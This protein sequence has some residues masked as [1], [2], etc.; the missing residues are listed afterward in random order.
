[1]I[2]VLLFAAAVTGLAVS[3]TAQDYESCSI[4]P[5]GGTSSN[6]NYELIGAAA[7]AEFCG[8]TEDCAGW[9]YTP[10]NFNPTGAPGECRWVSVVGEVTAASASASANFCGQPDA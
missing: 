10:H 1:M 2:R 4:Q 3:A 6:Y 5:G 8:A 9:T 7:C